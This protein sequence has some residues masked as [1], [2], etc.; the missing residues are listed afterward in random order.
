MHNKRGTKRSRQT[1][2]LVG[3]AG[4]LAGAVYGVTGMPSHANAA[5]IDVALASGGGVQVTNPDVSAFGANNHG[6]TPFLYGASAAG[7]YAM[8]GTSGGSPTTPVQL[9]TI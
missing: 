1:K 2:A 6:I 4:T 3:A 9:T 7:N 8:S 5:A